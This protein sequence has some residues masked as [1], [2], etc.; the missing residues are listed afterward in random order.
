MT[1]Q[2]M[3][4]GAFQF[5]FATAEALVKAHAQEM[6]L[7]NMGQSL[8][9]YVYPPKVSPTRADPPVPDLSSVV[10]RAFNEFY[11]GSE[12]DEIAQCISDELH[13][14]MKSAKKDV[15]KVVKKGLPLTLAN[16]R[17]AWEEKGP[18]AKEPT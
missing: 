5:V 15:A 14:W 4:D 3:I 17:L 11:Q 2:E 1:K 18:F 8:V 13:D 10:S 16:A 9:D 7:G 6:T 12:S